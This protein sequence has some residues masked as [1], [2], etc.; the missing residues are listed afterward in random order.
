MKVGEKLRKKRKE[1][2]LEDL[3]EILTAQDIADYIGISRRRVYELL[4]LKPDFGGIPNFEIG[5]TKRVEKK[6]LVMWINARKIEK[7]NSN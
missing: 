5:Q 1:T 7:A 6:D 3:P 4:Q 2:L